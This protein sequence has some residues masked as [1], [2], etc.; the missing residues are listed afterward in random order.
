MTPDEIAQLN[1]E[2]AESGGFTKGE[3]KKSILDVT[4]EA[5]NNVEAL[6]TTPEA[7]V[8]LV[9]FPGVHALAK[10]G[11]R[12]VLDDKSFRK[13]ANMLF[14]GKRLTLAKLVA[15]ADDEEARQSILSLADP[16]RQ[17]GRGEE[18]KPR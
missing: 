2:V 5:L 15:A 17:K 4:G 11:L 14:R 9:R 3:F 10:R 1:A 6:L 8:S 7:D 18:K 16:R 13:F 12:E